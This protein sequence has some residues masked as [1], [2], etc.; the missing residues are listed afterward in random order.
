M[1]L[2]LNKKQKQLL[3]IS[4]ISLLLFSA[5]IPI[6]VVVANNQTQNK[7]QPHQEKEKDIEEAPKMRIDR[8]TTLISY[9]YVEEKNQ[10][11]VVIESDLRQSITFSDVF[12]GISGDS[13]SGGIS[14]IPQQ[15]LVL[16]QG[17]N[18]L[19]FEVT[20]YQG[21]A[22]LGLAT[23]RAAINVVNEGGNALFSGSPRWIDVQSSA[24]AGLFIG[25]IIPVGYAF[26]MKYKEPEEPRR[27]L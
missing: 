27:K 14:R 7:N 9:T 23:P 11:V 22:V 15:Q 25:G 13:G 6:P 18:R 10:F 26:V 2:K 19:K 3:S 8:L 21:K 20:E 12:S 4:F 5:F 16:D 17:V 1:K 24:L